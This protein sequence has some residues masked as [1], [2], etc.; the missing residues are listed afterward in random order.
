[1]EAR[2]P[3]FQWRDINWRAAVLVLASGVVLRV[4]SRGA[5]HG[6]D[7]LAWQHAAEL[8]ADGGVVYAE[9]SR[10]NYGPIWFLILDL[11][12]QLTE[13][14]PWPWVA[15]R[16]SITSL[17]ILVDVGI[18]C[19]LLRFLCFP[20][21]ALFFLNPISIVASSYLGQ[22]DN[23]ALLIGF[24]AVLLYPAELDAP[25]KG[26]KLAALLVLGLSLMT[27]HVLF[28]FPLWL[29][30]KEKSVRRAPVV[31]AVPVLVFL[32]GFAPY[33]RVGSEGIIQHVFLY[34]S[35]EMSPFWDFLGSPLAA[36]V[37]K[38]VLF[39]GTL[40][41]LSVVFRR[42]SPLESFF[43]YCGSMFLFTP[44]IYA[45]YMAIPVLFLAVYLNLPLALF[46][47][48]VSWHFIFRFLGSPVLYGL[49]P[50]RE[51]REPS[52]IILFSA[53]YLWAVA[54]PSLKRRA[55]RQSLGDAIGRFR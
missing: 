47:F 29:A 37:P 2:E 42:R 50:P 25:L 8:M 20:I 6:T 36:F 14:M 26:R 15:F 51:Y 44:S 9:T 31:L 12:R 18:Y 52:E 19:L 54:I 28:V 43:I 39:V 3:S 1:M 49:V 35:S 23:L 11:L 7:V 55:L 5:G 27:K 13:W 10:Y 21:A 16:L 17:L 38:F 33:W 53:G 48:S 24:V 45:H 40:V 41:A 22:F 4:L 30:V 32:A 34:R 46:T